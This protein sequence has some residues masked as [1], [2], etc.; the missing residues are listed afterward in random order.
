M[1]KDSV[2]FGESGLTSTSANHVANL[3]K[4]YI[5]TIESYING[6][7]FTNISIKLIDSE[8]TNIIQAGINKDNLFTLSELL[9]RISESKSLI[10]WLRE[11]ISAKEKL[12]ED[13]GNINMVQWLTMNNITLERPEERHVLTEKEYYASLPIKERSRYYRLETTAAVIGK[14][15]HP[16]GAFASARKEMKNIISHPHRIEGSG[17]DAIIST[18]TP[19]VQ[20]YEV[21]SVFFDLQ[22]RY[23]EAQAQLNSMKHDCQLAINKSTVEVNTQYVNDLDKY[24]NEYQKQFAVYK[25]WKEAKNQEYS[26]LKIIIPD[27]LQGIYKIINTLG[28]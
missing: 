10:A 18:Y 17:R 12:L 9:D 27:S 14:Y 20:D 21:D 6:I 28:K 13:L 8:S 3:A 16:D 11:A 19:S 22:K 23:R 4:E 15:I 7:H 24:N 1:T 26:N 2:F 25:A 5:Q